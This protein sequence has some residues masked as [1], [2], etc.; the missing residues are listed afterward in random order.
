MK[1]RAS[2]NPDLVLCAV[3]QEEEEM[4]GGGCLGNRNEGCEE[5]CEESGEE[6]RECDFTFGN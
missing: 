5:G 4:V 1:I 2:R 3:N 6:E